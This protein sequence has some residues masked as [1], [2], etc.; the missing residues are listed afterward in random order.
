VCRKLFRVLLAG[1]LRMSFA[2]ALVLRESDRK[3]S[4]TWRDCRAC[5]WAWRSGRGC[6]SFAWT[7]DAYELIAKIRPPEN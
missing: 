3:N 7:K 2:P 6:Q 5:R 4:V 1:Q